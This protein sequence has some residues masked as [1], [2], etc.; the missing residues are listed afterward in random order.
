MLPYMNRCGYLVME[1]SS[2]IRGNS[3]STGPNGVVRLQTS[4]PASTRRQKHR[5]SLF[6]SSGVG[7]GWVGIGL[8]LGWVAVLS[9][10]FLR[11][12]SFVGILSFECFVYVL[13]F[14]FFSGI[15]LLGLF[16]LVS[17]V[18]F[19]VWILLF[20]LCLEFFF[21]VFR[22]DSFR[23]ILLFGSFSGSLTREAWLS[24]WRREN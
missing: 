6:W 2:S 9:F 11:L 5:G 8:G 19:F 14:G 1:R 20:G 23:W 22:L 18:W 21:G 4:P 17:F 12:D 13:L 7:C 3:R 10:G 24:G 16:S 15:L